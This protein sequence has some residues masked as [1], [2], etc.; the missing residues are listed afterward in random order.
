MLEGDVLGQY[1]NAS[2]SFEVIAIKNTVLFK[3]FV[4]KLAALPKQ[5]ID[6]CRF[7]MINVGNDH[8]IADILVLD[9]HSAGRV[10]CFRSIGAFFEF[11]IVINESDIGKG[12]SLGFGHN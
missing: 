1:R 12:V 7:T 9:F 2:F 6:K 5:A 3:L 8:N 11:G 4:P 10:N